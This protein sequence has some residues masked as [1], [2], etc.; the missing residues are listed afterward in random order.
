MNLLLPVALSLCVGLMMT[1]IFKKLGLKLPDVTAFL[2]AGVA[3]G[4]FVLGAFGIEGLGFTS[5]E[6]VEATS[7]ISNVALGF[8]AFDI[9]NEFR[10]ESLKKTGRQALLIGIFQAL[11][12]TA[13]VDLVLVLISVTTH[14][15]SISAAITLGAIASA[16]APAATLMVVRQY[17]AKGPLTDL[18]L[19]I[20]ALDD[21]VGL[22]IFAVSLGIAQA[23]KG[24]AV[25]VVTVLVNPLLEIVCSLALG[26][27]MGAVMTWMEKMFFS[28]TNRLSMT[29]SFVMMTIALAT[30][31]IELP[32]GLEIGFSS[33]LVCM[34]L[35]TI[36]CNIS[37]FSEDIMARA[38]KWTAPLSAVFFVLS[39]AELD[40]S[41]FG[42]FAIVGVGM[43]YILTRSA[44]KYFGA[45]ISSVAAGC[46]AT[47]RK[48]LG[49]TLLPQAGVALGMVVSAQ[50]LGGDDAAIIKN[51]IL[52][53]VLIYELFGPMM[54][55]TALAAAGE[56][57]AKPVEKT[58]RE[59]FRENK[60][61][62]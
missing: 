58:T 60:R 21:A 37:E 53:A 40:I 20:V 5:L 33:L 4:P 61:K 30:I 49:I 10:L 36:F 17:K 29:I 41:L 22:I 50:A 48:Y 55:K 15:L 27:L 3:V 47:V 23:I 24:G 54:T 38:E 31:K 14:I 42:N 8:I 34:M 46:S 57:A 32:G 44:G 16:T 43:I 45:S 2:I 56:I 19:P 59:R 28:N 39:G 52:F 1:R 11:A 18:L 6:Q 9:G 51:I 7:V 13:V 26:A 35:G 12:A 25:S 62:K